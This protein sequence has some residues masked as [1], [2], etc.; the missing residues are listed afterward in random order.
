[1][2][3]CRQ[4]VESA[5]AKRGYDRVASTPGRKSS[6]PNKKQA[7]QTMNEQQALNPEVLTALKS[8]LD[9]KLEVL[10][11]RLSAMMDNKIAELEGKLAGIG[12]EITTVREDFNESIHHVENILRQDIDHT[13]EYAVQNE[14]Y[15][16]KNNLR[17]LGMAEEEEED[18]EA[19]F[20]ASM[21]E[22]LGEIKAEDVEIIHRIDHRKAVTSP[23]DPRTGGQ[24]STPKPRPVIV[25][26]LS[27]KTKSRLLLKRRL[28]K[29]KKLVILEDMAH[30]L[31]KRLKKLKE[32]RSVDTAWFSNGKIKFKFKDGPRI[33]ELKGWMELDNIE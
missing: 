31:A 30:D 26:L 23:G 17:I 32:K 3:T 13:W 4:Q 16:R 5:Q 25:R 15:S 22:N 24:R 20:I 18:L 8:I 21:K 14:Q 33:M 11:E 28:L 10:A 1:M 6:S 2:A 12:K 9:E 19:K 29:G 7:K 27:N